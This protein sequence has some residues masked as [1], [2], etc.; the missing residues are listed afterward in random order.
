MD[1]GVRRKL[2]T[3]WNDMKQRLEKFLWTKL[4]GELSRKIL[5]QLRRQDIQG[6]PQNLSENHFQRLIRHY[7]PSAPTIL[8]SNSPKPNHKKNPTVVRRHLLHDAMMEAVN[9]DVGRYDQGKVNKEHVGNDPWMAML[10]I[11]DDFGSNND[12]SQSAYQ[13]QWQNHPDQ[14]NSNDLVSFKTF[15]NLK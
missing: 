11:D 4:N 9:K 5:V 14:Y 6:E 10:N 12:P 7:I 8:V 3:E 2:L 1:P 15:H 13:V